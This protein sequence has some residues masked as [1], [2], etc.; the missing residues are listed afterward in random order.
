MTRKEKRRKNK[1]LDDYEIAQRRKKVLSMRLAG[2][3]YRETAEALG[4]S[5]ST[6]QKD[7]NAEL[8]EI[9]KW[10]ADEL[11]HV[12]ERRLNR[13][14]RA[15]WPRALEGDLPAFDRVLRVMERRAKMLGLDMPQRVEVTGVDVD[16]DTTVEKLL[17]VAELAGDTH[18]TNSDSGK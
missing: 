1:T 16:L 13:L 15:I 4:I 7:I 2:A 11:R 3:T 6:V 14:Q 5:P 8:K 9:P 17:R 12:E 10:R 18:P